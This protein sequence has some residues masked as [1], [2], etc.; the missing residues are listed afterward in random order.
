MLDPEGHA[1]DRCRDRLGAATAAFAAARREAVG[2]PEVAAGSSR[3]LD[4]LDFL[5]ETFG[6]DLHDFIRVLQGPR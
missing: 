4:A 5:L 1:L 2:G 3:G 6:K